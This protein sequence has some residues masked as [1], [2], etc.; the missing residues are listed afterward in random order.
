MLTEWLPLLIVLPLLTGFLIQP[1]SAAMGE[2]GPLVTN[3]LGLGTMVAM[4][5]LTLSLGDVVAQQPISLVMGGFVAS[6]GINLYLDGLA[7]LLLLALLIGILLLWPQGR[8][9][10]EQVLMLLLAASSA[11]MALSGDLFNLYVFYELMAV[12]TFGLVAA[13]DSRAGTIVG[14][15]YLLLS[16]VGAVLALSGIALIYSH[17]GTL[18]LAHLAQLVASGETTLPISA[19]LL[20]LLGFGVK[21]EL[22]AVNSW[23]PEVYGAISPRLSALLAGVVSKLAVVMI[24]RV[25][26]LLFP[27]EA[28]TQALLVLGI[29]GAVSGELAA[30][31]AHDLRRM[32][33]YSS[34]GQL[35][36]IFIAFSLSV[37]VGLMVG[38][39]LSFHHLLVKPGMFL[40][41]E[42]TL[43]RWGMALFVIFA[44][45]LVGVPPMPG[46][47]AK[48]SLLTG[49][50]ES[51][52]WLNAVAIAAFLFATVVEAGYLF[53]V[54]ARYYHGS[55]T[56][57]EVDEDSSLRR[58]FSGL[59]V[60]TVL[61]A[62]LLYSAW[63]IGEVAEGMKSVAHQAGDTQLLISVVAP[64]EGGE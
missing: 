10:R 14:F 15:R 49:L 43:N 39:A 7:W 13:V 59:L 26:I 27:T 2:R 20:I 60:S 19:F 45:S 28:A 37:E 55:G 42:Q 30:W 22:F 29:L 51:G 36:M 8:P 50:V 52:G 31:R 12:A 61:A 16:G 9:P 18:N 6:M 48:F 21:A 35:G 56:I 47:W 32:L 33:A 38:I 64:Q 62:G 5:L 53:R 34:I 63:E 3:W 44:L 25:L 24:V 54:V 1:L 58:G 41:T 11:G 46:F 40:L 17:S 4:L 57:V 23:V